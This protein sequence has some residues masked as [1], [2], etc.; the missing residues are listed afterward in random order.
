MEL[1]SYYGNTNVAPKY[2]CFL[3]SV[4]YYPGQKYN[5]PYTKNK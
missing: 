5:R 1:E 2:N 4:W 3:N